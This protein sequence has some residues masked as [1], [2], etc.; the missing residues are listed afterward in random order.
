MKVK[1]SKVD[2]FGF[3]SDNDDAER[4]LYRRELLDALPTLIMTAMEYSTREDSRILVVVLGCPCC[5]GD[6]HEELLEWKDRGAVLVS[7]FSGIDCQGLP[8]HRMNLSPPL[9]LRGGER[10]GN[11]S[12]LEELADAFRSAIESALATGAG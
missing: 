9:S 11:A 3:P 7:A 8:I 6:L 10:E 2:T 1:F 4:W 12:N 5:R